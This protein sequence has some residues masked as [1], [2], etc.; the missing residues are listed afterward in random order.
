MRPQYRPTS[1][2]RSLI[3]FGCLGALVASLLSCC[4][5]AGLAMLPI[6]TGTVPPPPAADATRP[7]I[8]IIVP[9]EFLVRSLTDVLPEG[10]S[11]EATFD[12]QPA[13]RMVFQGKFDLFLV[14]LDV[15]AAFRLLVQGGQLQFTIESLEAGGQDFA[16]LFGTSIES[17]TAQMSD[18]MQEQIETGLGAGAQI[19]AIETTDQELI[20]EAR[21]EPQE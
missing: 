3:T 18:L 14:E 20:I 6:F 9:E 17:L 13:N 16:E 8:T 4:L 10:L 11:G 1:D 2:R 15:N 12:I 19:L 5:L 21:W 7:D